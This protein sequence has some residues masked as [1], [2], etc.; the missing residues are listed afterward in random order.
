MFRVEVFGLVSPEGLELTAFVGFRVQG[1]GA[2]GRV[3]HGGVWSSM[4]MGLVFKV[5]AGLS[6]RIGEDF[7]G[8]RP[9]GPGSGVQ[10]LRCAVLS[11]VLFWV[12]FCLQGL[13]FRVHGCGFRFSDSRV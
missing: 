11:P 10:S 13:R 8:F 5:W 7:F 9:S 12:R 6:L 3:W 2:W 1:R 4:L